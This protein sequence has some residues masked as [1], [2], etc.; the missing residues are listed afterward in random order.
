MSEKTTRSRW[1]WIACSSWWWPMWWTLLVWALAKRTSRTRWRSKHFE[2]LWWTPVP[3]WEIS[4]F[5]LWSAPS[6]AG[7]ATARST[8]WMPGDQLLFSWQ[9]SSSRCLW[10]ARQLHLPC[11]RAWSTLPRPLGQ[12]MM[13]STGSL[14]ASG[15]TPNPTSLGDHLHYSLC[16]G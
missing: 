1:S 10:E 5:L 12:N 4:A 11:M 7:C 9:T 13:W 6:G 2:T 8:K 14:V 15:S 16:V 3:G